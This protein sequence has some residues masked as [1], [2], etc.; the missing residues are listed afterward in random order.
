MYS[1]EQTE[2]NTSNVAATGI[3]ADALQYYNFGLLTDD[4]YITINP[5][6]QLYYKR[7][8]L[9]GM[10][11]AT[12]AFDDKYM[13][14]ATIRS[15]GA[16]VLADGHQWHT[17]P[18][19]SVGWNMKKEAFLANVGWLDNLKPRIGYGQTSNQ[20]INPYETMGGLAT[21]Y[22]NFGEKNVSG[23]Y[24]STLP[25]TN[26]GWE[27]ST[28]WNFAVEFGVLSNRLT[29]TIE[30]YTQ[31]TQDVLISQQ[32]PTTSG[33]KGTYMV[34][35]GE[36]ANSGFELSLNGSVLKN[37]NGWD[38]DIGFNLYANSNEILSL[39]S[40]STYDKGN[41]WFVGQPINVIYDY[42]KIGIW[43]TGEDPTP[44]E[45]ST[46][47]VGM[48]K[49]EYTGGYNADGTPTRV[50]GQGTTLEDD[51]R[52]FLGSADPDFAGGFNTRVGYKGFELSLVGT[53]KSGG[54]LISSLHSQTSY[55][56][57]NNGRYGQISI[58]YWTPTNPT[59]AYPMPAGPE[60]TNNPKYASTLAYFDASYCKISTITLAY[61]FKPEW[62]KKIN[63]DRL[64]LYVMAQNPLIFASPYYTE[65]GLDP[66]PNSGGREN[67]S[68]AENSVVPSRIY[69]VAYNTPATR[70]FLLGL[71]ITF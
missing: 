11:R 37:Y 28:T 58:D 50:I 4:G 63:V 47:K 17:Y 34:N 59:N 62:L 36:T 51:D 29:G 25:N 40:G 65:T 6:K 44:Y 56:N 27:Y 3:T 33:T 32:L 48:I 42:K 5:T 21:N 20:S 57:L 13:L 61:N 14:S 1:A 30:Y 31:N 7:G 45:G 43:Q 52:Q 38:W 22:Y 64:R 10:F 49:V 35:M 60:S 2:S 69:I 71:N 66:Q 55:K 18:A 70:N 16:S 54:L 67:Q 24:V 23:Y 12:Y 8:L 15:D 19:V 9:S 68:V 46:G 53:F 26:L 41:G 39:A